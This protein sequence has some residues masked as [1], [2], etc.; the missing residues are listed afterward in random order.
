MVRSYEDGRRWQ[1]SRHIA[2]SVQNAE[3][4][5]RFLNGTV[6]V[7]G[8]YYDTHK[9]TSSDGR[10]WK[11]MYDG[12]LHC[13]KNNQPALMKMAGDGKHRAILLYLFKMCF[14]HYGNPSP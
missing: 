13:Q 6:D 5:A 8:D 1:A 7:T 9:V 14:I 4:V 12:S 11:I 3:T 2:L 10:V